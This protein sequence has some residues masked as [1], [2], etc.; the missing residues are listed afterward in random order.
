MSA[1][2]FRAM[3]KKM[4]G[5]WDTVDKIAGQKG[6]DPPSGRPAGP[7][8]PWMQRHKFNAVRVTVDGRKYGSKAEAAYAQHLERE[9]AAGRL[10]FFLWQVPFHIPGNPTAIRLVL[11]FVEFWAD[12]AITF[13]DVKGMKL[14]TFKIKQR[15]AQAHYPIKIR[16]VRMLKG[17]PVYEE[18]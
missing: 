17:G 8:A 3:R 18:T 15:G 9:K 7:R 1:E 14:D 10:V 4:T 2:E 6:I 11:D 16:T 5:A 13:T 12:Q